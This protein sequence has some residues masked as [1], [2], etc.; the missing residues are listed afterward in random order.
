MWQ[1]NSKKNKCKIRSGE[2]TNEAR[3]DGWERI[4]TAMVEAA[5]LCL[6]D[7]KCKRKGD[8]FDESCK[9]YFEELL[10][11]E[12]IDLTRLENEQQSKSSEQEEVEK[13]SEQ[14]IWG[15]I[16]ELENDKSAGENGI[17]AEILKNG[18]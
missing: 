18:G 14:E 5:S 10:N 6:G 9:R 2:Q 8:W 4:Y 1:N 12:E 3:R 17:S 16:K 13:S 7:K 15:I 11:E